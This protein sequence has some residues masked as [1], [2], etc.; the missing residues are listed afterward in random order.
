MTVCRREDDREGQQH[1]WG[2]LKSYLTSK[3]RCALCVHN[4]MAMMAW[5]KVKT[6]IAEMVWPEA[7]MIQWWTKEV[8]KNREWVKWTAHSKLISLQQMDIT[9]PD[10]KYMCCFQCAVDYRVLKCQAPGH[11]LGENFAW[12][13]NMSR[14]GK[15][16]TINWKVSG[17]FSWW[18]EAMAANGMKVQGNKDW[19]INVK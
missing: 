8:A 3:S 9:E 5:S 7:V 6:M 11:I 18:H 14:Y 17:W 16:T 1:K 19:Y 12:K 13:D 15:W 2:K 4:K 10:G